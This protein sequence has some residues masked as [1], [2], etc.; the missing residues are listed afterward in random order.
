MSHFCQSHFAFAEATCFPWNTSY[1][2][3][4][5]NLFCIY[6]QESVRNAADLAC[7]S[8]SRVGQCL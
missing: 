8:L 7:R 3:V 4:G 5:E 2:E 1:Y 6:F